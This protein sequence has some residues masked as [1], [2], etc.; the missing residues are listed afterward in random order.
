MDQASLCQVILALGVPAPSGNNG[1]VIGKEVR[2]AAFTTRA[3]FHPLGWLIDTAIEP[4][5]G[6]SEPC[7]PY[8]ALWQSDF[9]TEGDFLGLGRGVQKATCPYE[10]T[11]AAGARLAARVS[12]RSGIVPGKQSRLAFVFFD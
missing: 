1:T 12:R 8:G 6:R 11:V 5:P 3:P 10:G 9:A 7:H 2:L 4:S